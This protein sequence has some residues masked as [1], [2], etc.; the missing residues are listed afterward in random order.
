MESDGR[1][2]LLLD[3]G[4]RHFDFHAKQRLN[5]F[6]IYI[7]LCGLI[8]AAWANIMTSEDPDAGGWGLP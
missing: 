7:V 6:N 2:R 5:V 1:D 8:V 4:W 3:H